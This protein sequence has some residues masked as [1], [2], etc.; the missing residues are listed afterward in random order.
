METIIMSQREV[1]RHGIIKRLID[2]KIN[3]TEASKLLKLSLRQVRRL[4]SVVFE[5]GAKGLVHGNRGKIGNRSLSEEERKKIVS[6]LHERYS[7]FKP[8]FAC[9]KL[10]ECHEIVHDPKTIRAIQIKEGLW[11]PRRKKAGS[12]HRSWRQRRSYY[13]E[14]EQFDGSYE[15]WFEDRGPKC[16]LLAS[17][18]DATGDVTKATFG[19][20]EGVI[21]VFTF[22]KE[23]LEQHGKPHSIYLDKFSTYKMNCKEA[24]DNPDLK[25][26]FKRAADELHMELIFANSPQ[27]KGRVERLFQT[28]QD[29][30]IKE[31]RL[32]NVSTIEEGNIFLQSYLPKFNKQFSVEATSTS[33]LHNK[34]NNKELNNLFSVFSRQ[35]TRVVQNDFT[36]AHNT[37]WYQLTEKQPVTVCKRDKVIVEERLDGSVWIRLR[38]KYLAYKILPER[39]KR[40]K[41]NIWVL[42]NNT[43]TKPAIDHP[44]RKQIAKDCAISKLTH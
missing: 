31:M 4:K 27:A 21:P 37:N 24:K 36:I 17:I 1:D 15:Y 13:G 26:Q 5:K 18:D 14:M 42:T 7:D 19:F 43:V 11:K 35:E 32:V 30:L 29:R 6:L 9:E 16:C 22:W 12:Q 23:Y 44:W 40:T 25:T 41:T 33:D 2:C 3:G 28:F 8:T 39:P 38:G 34:L 10:R 20:N